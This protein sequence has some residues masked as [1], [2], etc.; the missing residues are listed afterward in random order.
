MDARTKL[1]WYWMRY[2]QWKTHAGLARLD[3]VEWWLSVLLRKGPE[4]PPLNTV[5]MMQR[6]ILI[7]ENFLKISLLMLYIFALPTIHGFITA[8]AL[9]V[10]KHV[11]KP[12]AKTA[13][14]ARKMVKLLNTG[15]N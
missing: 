2:S 14:D 7:T 11:R 12:M 9:E 13:D 1:G 10:S 15:K 3:C 8:D 4:K 5:P 6:C